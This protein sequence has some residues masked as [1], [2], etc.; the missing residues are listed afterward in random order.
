MEWPSPRVMVSL[1]G[2]RESPARSIIE[3]RSWNSMLE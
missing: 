3:G 1:T 2:V